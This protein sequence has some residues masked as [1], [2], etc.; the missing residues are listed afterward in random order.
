VNRLYSRQGDAG[1][2]PQAG[3]HDLLA[4]AF[5]DGRDE[6]PVVPRVH[7][8]TFNGFLPRKDGSNLWPE[9]SAERFRF[10]RRQNDRHVEH[11][12]GLGEGDRVVDDRLAIEVAGPEQHLRLMVDQRHDA[13]VGSQESLLTQLGAIA[14]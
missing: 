9:V 4:A 6:V 12:G 2:C 10:H 7:G 3:E 8:R 5:L 11:A 14:V 13:I 1:L